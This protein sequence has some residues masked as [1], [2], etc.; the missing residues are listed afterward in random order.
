[1]LKKMSHRRKEEQRKIL[2]WRRSCVETQME[3]LGF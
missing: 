3:R 2:R 1:M